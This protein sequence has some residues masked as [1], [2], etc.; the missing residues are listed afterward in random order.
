MPSK[1]KPTVKKHS[2]PMAFFRNLYLY[3]VCGI[4]IVM[5]L[6][7]SISLVRIA[8]DTYVFQIDTPRYWHSVCDEPRVVDSAKIV[9]TEEELAACEEKDLAKAK[10]ELTHD[11]QRDV[12][13]ALAMLLVT[14][15]LYWFH[16][17][18]IQKDHNK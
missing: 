1:K 15:P 16:W 2:S 4:T 5:I 13:E 17:R 8:L 3:L 14:L 10:A 6:I 18:T 12:S 9:M 7:A 11:R